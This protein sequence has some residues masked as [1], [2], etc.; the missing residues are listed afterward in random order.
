M[1]MLKRG[2]KETNHAASGVAIEM[3]TVFKRTN[4]GQAAIF[5][6]LTL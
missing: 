3:Y 1:Q 2:S 6:G 5:A 4:G